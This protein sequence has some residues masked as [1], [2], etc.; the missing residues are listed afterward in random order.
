MRLTQLSLSSFRNYT[1]LD[2]DVPSGPIL[3]VGDNAQGKTSLLEAIYYLA[4][5]DSF[6]ASSL[7][8]LINLLEAEREALAVARIVARFESL[9]QPHRLEIRLIQDSS[10]RNGAPQIRKEIVY[11]NQ[12]A[13]TA[14]VLGQFNAVLFLPQMLSIVDGAPEER[15]RYLNLALSQVEP[16]YDQAL[17]DYNKALSQRNA[18]LKQLYERQGDPTQLDFWDEVLTDAGAKLIQARSRAVLEL[19]RFA[20][21]IHHELTRGAEVLR[22]DY[23]PAYDP[24]TKITEPGSAADS[25]LVERSVIPGAEIRRGFWEQLAQ[26]RSEEIARGVTTIGPHRDELRIFSNRI[27]LGYYGSRGQVRTAMLSL[28]LAEVE[29]MKD[30][31]GQWPVLLLDEVLAELDTQRRQ[32]LLSRLT[33]SEQA[34]LTTTDLDLFNKTFIDNAT[35]WRIH[36][37]RLIEEVK[38]AL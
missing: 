7:R 31:T 26:V 17:S 18:L 29:W 5:L 13:R 11:D 37:G 15:R 3:I 12:K 34:L 4:T 1:R 30:K 28:K 22:L 2:V 35:L 24:L 10:I 33:H 20:R 32:D 19:D 23:R 6:H 16:A 14:E 38:H 9:N 8:Q 21:S 36:A 25:A 27:D